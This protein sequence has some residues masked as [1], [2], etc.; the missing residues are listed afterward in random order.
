MDTHHIKVIY[1]KTDE[2]PALAT[3]SLFPII[4]SFLSLAH[5]PIKL[6]DISLAGR[7]LALF[8]PKSKEDALAQLAKLVQQPTANIIKL[9]NIS[10]SIPQLKT[11]ILEL[12][13]Q[14]F[15]IPDFPENPTTDVQQD[16]RLKYR[17]VLGS[18]VN[19]VLREGNSDRRVAKPIKDYAQ[20]HP[21]T[22]GTWDSNVS[23][24]IASMREGDF[25]GSERSLVVSQETEVVI[26]LYDQQ[27]Q[28]HVLKSNIL[29]KE[30]DVIDTAVMSVEA[31]RHF[32]EVEIAD[33]REKNLLLSLHLKS[34]MMKISDPIIFSHCLKTYF[35]EAIQQYSHK[36]EEI[37][38][39]L[40]HGLGDLFAKLQSC[41]DTLR[42]EITQAFE[43]CYEKG[44]HL[45]MVDSDRGITCLH[46]PN[47]VIIDSSMPSLV[48]SSGKLWGPDGSMHFTK[49]LV[50]DRSYA[51]I[52]Q[53]VIDFCK[54][55]GAFD[56]K[57]MGSVANVGLMAKKAEEYGSHDKTFQIP[58]DGKIC[59]ED[60]SGRVLLEHA[61]KKGDIWRMCQ[62]KDEAIRDWVRLAVTRAKA[63]GVPAIFWLD[64]L[65]SHDR[66]LIQKVKKY[67][68]DHNTEDFQVLSP[69]DAMQMTLERIRSGQDTIAVTGNVLRDYLT[70][71]FPI[72]EVGTSAKML[73]I[74][75]LLAGGGLYETGAGGTAPRH[76][77]QF[78]KEN[79]LRWSSLGEFLALAV[80]LEDLSQKAVDEK[81]KLK[82]NVLARSLNR[83]NE[84][85]LK[86]GR[87]P[88]RRVQEL[89]TRGSHFYWAMYWAEA[90]VEVLKQD[91]D[92]AGHVLGQGFEQKS[93]FMADQLRSKAVKILEQ[94]NGVQGRP[95]DMGGYYHPDEALVTALMRPSPAFNAIIDNDFSALSE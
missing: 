66:C 90:I 58:I 41:P 86:E 10:A 51:G 60:I 78:L 38:V 17:K 33:A 1:T 89:D 73:S 82:M 72:L 87:S 24:H 75:P 4:Q 39:D 26:K 91:S 21:H 32:F 29:L 14:G 68:K 74:V 27:G 44:P 65:R 94:L 35:K 30:Q 54:K 43:K 23:T 31:L 85:F 28:S 67:L 81:T 11:A 3:A 76:V 64:S 59:V 9:P 71:L 34:T 49:A 61:V 83:A 22:M 55:H 63:T 7:I 42:D 70:D 47:D 92:L 20:T 62:T 57:T 8:Q 88:S 95:V 19:P 18:S 5:V 84:K 48:R 45:A 6:K 12:Q 46:F 93:L 52:Y 36:L 40:R 37:G 53:K 16:V 77:D 56:P 80:S 15:D 2:A 79:H 50:P 25:Y 13:N 69:I